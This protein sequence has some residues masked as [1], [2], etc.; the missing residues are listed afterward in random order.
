MSSNVQQWIDLM[1]AQSIPKP[2]LGSTHDGLEPIARA[3]A[4][5]N[6]VGFFFYWERRMETQGERERERELDGVWK[7]CI[8]MTSLSSPHLGRLN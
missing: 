6:P 1:Q 5:P 8:Q 7:T 2:Q 3:T 4:Q